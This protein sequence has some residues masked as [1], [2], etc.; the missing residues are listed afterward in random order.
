MR[1]LITGGTGFFGGHITNECIKSGYTT[2][3]LGRDANLTTDSEI[4]EYIK[5]W[6]P[7]IVIHAAGFNGGIEFNRLYPAKI[8]DTNLK[9]LSNV[10][11]ACVDSSVKRIVNIATSCAY[12]DL[13]SLV[14]EEDEF[15]SGQ[16][17]ESIRCHGVAKRTMQAYAE[18]YSKEH[19]IECVTAAVTNLY[20]PNDTFNLTRTKV[21]GA[22]I[23]KIVEAKLEEKPSVTFWG[24]GRAMRQ[25][26]YVKDAAV[27]IRELCIKYN[28]PYQPINIGSPE[29]FTIKELV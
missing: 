5:G 20:G 25:F 29:E 16:C 1:V 9:M 17:N 22:V 13:G 8:L 24:T 15:W 23:R 7:E 3:S 19:K 28:N 26:M 6:E 12:P 27:A 11:N 18:M 10:Y 14:M 4:N 2:L 21:V